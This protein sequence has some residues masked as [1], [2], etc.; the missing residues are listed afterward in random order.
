MIF[1]KTL[2]LLIGI[3]FSFSEIYDG[4]LLYSPAGGGG[5]QGGGGGNRYTQ[6][7]DNN[8]NIIHE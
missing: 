6:L 4:Y 8:L 1:Y 2:M 3:S 5:G 7:I